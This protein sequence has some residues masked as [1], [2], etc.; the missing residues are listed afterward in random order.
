M[1]KIVKGKIG[2]NAYKISKSWCLGVHLVRY[3]H[4]GKTLRLVYLR[5]KNH[6]HYVDLDIDCGLEFLEQ[7]REKRKMGE[8]TTKTD[9]ERGRCE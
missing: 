5:T 3:D 4:G 2:R 9:M 6:T 1:I 7:N 8:L